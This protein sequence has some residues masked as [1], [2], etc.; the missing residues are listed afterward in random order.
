MWVMNLKLVSNKQVMGKMAIKHKVSLTGYTLSYWKDDKWLYLITC[1]LIFG[2]EKNKKEFIKSLR[3]SDDI[4]RVEMNG[5]F[6]IIE[7]R[8]PLWSEPFWDSRIIRPA[9]VII[10]WKERKHIW[11][12]ASFDKKILMNVYEIAKKTRNAELLK[13]KEEKLSDI[14]ITRMIPKL[15]KKQ[16]M[17]LEIAINNGY[18]EYPK[19]VKM[20]KLAGIMKL[21]YSTYQAHLKKAEGK[22]IPHVY[23]EL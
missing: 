5:D 19:K 9:P 8:Q 23:R 1:G 22:L 13:L 10:N 16:K 18:Y 11:Y 15:T 20:E 21:S 17:A 7:I 14:S 4:V 3:K 6:G 12:M 2:E